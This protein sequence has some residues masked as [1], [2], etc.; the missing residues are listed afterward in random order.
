MRTVLH[1]GHLLVP[2][3]DCDT[4]PLFSHMMYLDPTSLACLDMLSLIGRYGLRGEIFPNALWCLISA[5]VS[6]RGVL[7]MHH[8]A[9][10]SQAQGISNAIMWLTASMLH[11][12]CLWE[13]VSTPC[14]SAL[15]VVR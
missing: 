6:T 15:F 8:P 1:R 13:G 10:L 9:I 7:G 3:L 11:Q 2:P 5:G 4:C 14:D 12:I